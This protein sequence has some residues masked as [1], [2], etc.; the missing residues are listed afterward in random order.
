[1]KKGST[2]FHAFVV[3]TIGT[4][5]FFIC[6][7]GFNLK[8]FHALKANLYLMLLNQGHSVKEMMIHGTFFI[9]HFSR[10]DIIPT[11]S[12]QY[13]ALTLSGTARLISFENHWNQNWWELVKKGPDMAMLPLRGWVIPLGTI[14]D[15][16]V[17]FGVHLY[18]KWQELVKKWA[19]Y[20]QF[21]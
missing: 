19:R 18:P 17:T 15:N 2:Q 4:E 11:L 6:F 20:G 12:W 13:W 5:T 8:N 9:Y 1:M 10:L 21:L 16:G 14:W 7:W 3:D